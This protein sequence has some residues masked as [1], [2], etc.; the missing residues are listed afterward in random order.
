MFRLA[1]G[2][3]ELRAVGVLA[4]ISHREHARAIVDVDEVF[5]FELAAIDALTARSIGVLE[6]AAL[7]HKALD[8]AVEERVLE[9][10]RLAALTGEAALARAQAAKIFARPWHNISK[11]LDYESASAA[12]AN[13]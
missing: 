2:N 12:T 5:V 7:H 4:R 8:H 3:E 9:V 1:K 6:V 11:E 10:Q 13:L